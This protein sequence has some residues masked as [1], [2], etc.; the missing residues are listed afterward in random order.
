MAVNRPPP[1]LRDDKR[2]SE[3]TTEL[4]WLATRYE[5]PI[6]SC[7][8]TRDDPGPDPS[9]G[10]GETIGQAA[11]NAVRA[12]LLRAESAIREHLETHPL[13]EWAQEVM[14]LRDQAW[15]ADRDAVLAAS[16]LVRRLGGEVQVSDA[17]LAAAGGRLIREPA[18]WG[19]T[20]RTSA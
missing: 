5:C 17:E 10:T 1:R 7:E 9:E 4:P 20:L 18:P 14:R 6:G 3:Y 8:W 16:V 19:F 15:R 2:V 11:E 12:Y 13:L